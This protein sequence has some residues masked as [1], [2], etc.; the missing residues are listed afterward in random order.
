MVE[1]SHHLTDDQLGAGFARSPASRAN[2]FVF[3]DALRGD[4][5]RSNLI[6][7]LD[8]GRFPRREAEL[9]EALETELRGRRGRALP[10]EPRPRPVHVRP[11]KMTLAP[12]EP[13]PGP[14]LPPHSQ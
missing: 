12:H 13:T 2:R 6:W 7:Q 1:V 8:L 4:R 11:E 10:R 5:L 3:V 14:P 9:L